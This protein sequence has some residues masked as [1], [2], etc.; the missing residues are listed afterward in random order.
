[1][2]SLSLRLTEEAGECTKD[3]D[4]DGLGS[5]PGPFT[6]QPSELGQLFQFSKPYSSHLSNIDNDSHLTGLWERDG[7]NSAQ[8]EP[9][10]GS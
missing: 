4:L 10:V 8:V 2:V 1:M 3:L 7:E 5:N 9:T 6:Y